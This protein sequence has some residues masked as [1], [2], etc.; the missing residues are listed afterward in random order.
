MPRT[1]FKLP[2]GVVLISR[3]TDQPRRNPRKGAPHEAQRG[4][5]PDPS[6]PE[7]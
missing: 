6:R 2:T 5:G 7:G 1:S 3:T 4:W